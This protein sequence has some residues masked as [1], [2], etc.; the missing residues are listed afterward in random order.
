[1]N[2]S[3]SCCGEALPAV[4]AGRAAVSGQGPCREEDQERE[5]AAWPP[6]GG[7]WWVPAAGYTRLA[8]LLAVLSR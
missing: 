2:A 6:G 7:M 4:S 1:M 3:A 5:R 8:V